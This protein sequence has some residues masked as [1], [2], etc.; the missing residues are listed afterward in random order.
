MMGSS[1]YVGKDE[2]NTFRLPVH[3]RLISNSVLRHFLFEIPGIDF[4]NSKYSLTEGLKKAD[5]DDT[6]T[7]S[8][9]VKGKESPRS[10]KSC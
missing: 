6:G 2:V 3:D 9:F 5:G 7:K 8:G 1:C 10:S 4:P